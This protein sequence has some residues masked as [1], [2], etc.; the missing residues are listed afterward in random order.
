ML[1]AGHEIDSS[2][3]SRSLQCHVC[4]KVYTTKHGLQRHLREYHEVTEASNDLAP[5]VVDALCH[6]HEAVRVNDCIDLL[7]LDCVKQFVTS[8]CALCNRV[9]NRRQ[10][11]TRHFSQNHSALWTESLKRAMQLDNLYKPTHGCLCQPPLT[12]KHVCIVFQQFSL[13]RTGHELQMRTAALA[14][15]P[16]PTLNTVELLEPLRWQGQITMLYRK[17]SL[18]IRLASFAALRADPERLFNII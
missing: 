12:Y 11:F 8:R 4:H 5:E 16:E 18:R 1:H 3:S 7:Q 9:F 14:L 15:P 2:T 17:N 6:L 13:L 10:E